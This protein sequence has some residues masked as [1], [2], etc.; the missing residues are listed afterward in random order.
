[1][2]M[3]A[4]GNMK[5]HRPVI[6]V[7]EDQPEHFV[8]LENLL[9][10]L[11]GQEA[12]IRWAES[13]DDGLAAL[14]R[15]DYDVAL[16]DYRLGGKNGLELVE[17]V[18]HHQLTVPLIIL[19]GHADSELAIQALRSGA[20]DYLDKSMLIG[21][22]VG[23]KL[24]DR[25]ISFSIE[26]AEQRFRDLFDS[27]PDP[28]VVFDE[29][30]MIRLVNT[31]AEG[32]FGQTREGMIGHHVDR[33][34]AGL[35][36][37]A[38]KKARQDG[39]LDPRRLPDSTVEAVA[40]TDHGH[41]PIEVSLGLHHTEAGAIVLATIRDVSS[42]RAFERALDNAAIAERRRLGE[43]LHDGLAQKLTGLAFMCK[44]LEQKVAKSAP[45]VA[46]HAH[47]LAELTQEMLADVRDLARG[48]CPVHI[49]VE[50]FMTALR[51]LADNMTKRFGVPCLLRYDRPIEVAD[52]HLATNLYLIVQEAV[53]NAMKHGRAKHV[54]VRLKRDSDGTHIWIEDDGVGMKQFP[55][56]GQGMGL[57]TINHRATVI[58]AN[59]EFMSR[60]GSGL[61]VV[62]SL[63][64]KDPHQSHDHQHDGDAVGALDDDPT[65]PPLGLRPGDF[66]IDPDRKQ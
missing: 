21:T 50:S 53:T 52:E 8:L 4:H 62:C 20:T 17:Q 54:T 46:E 1:M 58:G 51:D 28:V 34:L 26:R 5:S 3:V 16:I 44:R 59:V 18:R 47:G 63:P 39:R 48:L 2:V 40:V 38:I 33:F 42:R 30:G 41:V 10:H 65:P 27:G 32:M 56:H 64:L 19:T 37:G 22:D 7:V 9:Q 14:N 29:Q 25:A 55:V 60:P 6:V 49:G 31:R 15:T 66:F 36:G 57:R 13:F 23:E 35:A 45:R 11:Y 24:L 61:T 43:D 12:V